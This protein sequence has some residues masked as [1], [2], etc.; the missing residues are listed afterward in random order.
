MTL[1]M[2]HPFTATLCGPTSSGKT[3]WIFRLIEHMDK[4][5][6]PPLSKVMYCYGEYQPIFAKYPNVIFNEGL[7]DIRQF[8]GREPLLLI[9]DDLMDA[10]NETV[11]A[12]F[13]KISHHRII[14][15]IYITQNLFPKNKH[16]RTISL[17]S[18]YMILFKNPRDAG[19]F[20]T[21]LVRCIRKDRRLLSRHLKMRQSFRTVTYSSISNRIRRNNI[22]WERTYFRTNWRM[23][24]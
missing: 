7:P 1:P 6:Q 19:Q 17:N 15:V 16:A 22:D 9:L 3:V 20:A 21:W 2:K 23:R 10:T 4:M 8:D 5:I 14:S 24:I 12:I 11:S 13:T 18:H